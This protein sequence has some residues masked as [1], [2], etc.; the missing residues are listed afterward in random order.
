MV[1]V[2][3]I[4]YF[5]FTPLGYFSS[6]PKPQQCFCWLSHWKEWARDDVIPL[7]VKFLEFGHP[8]PSLSSRVVQNKLD[9]IKK[10]PPLSPVAIF[11]LGFHG[12]PP[13]VADV[14]VAKPLR[15]LALSCVQILSAKLF[16]SLL[17]IFLSH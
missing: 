17:F 11:I 3:A 10:A 1:S 5:K 8:Q 7:S 12:G 13:P 6:L 14:M 9:G 15:R 4:P 16:F 2:C